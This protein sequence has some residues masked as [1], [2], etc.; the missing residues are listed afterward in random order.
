MSAALEAEVAHKSGNSAAIA[1][2]E[3]RLGLLTPVLKGV[4]TDLGFDNCVAAQQ[5]LGGHGYIAEWGMEQFVRDA[6]IA[7]IYEGANGIQ[8]LDLVGRKLPKDGGPR[9]LGLCGRGLGRHRGGRRGRGARGARATHGAGPRP[10]AAGHALVHDPRDRQARQ[11]RRR[12]STDYMHLFGLVALGHMWLLMAQGRRRQGAGRHRRAARDEQARDWRR[13]F[14]ERMVPESAIAARPHH[15]SGADSHHGLAG[16]SVL[17]S[18]VSP[19]PLA[20][21]GA[22]K[23]RMRGRFGW[24]PPPRPAFG[25]LLPRGEKGIACEVSCRTTHRSRAGRRAAASAAPCAM[26]MARAA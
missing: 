24:H 16:R 19:S 15:G 11:C 1:A 5:V 4:C 26:S 7:M 17:D 3:D 9:L 6:R 2:A 8:A 13:F 20:G 22:P 18:R 14:M 25:H 10:P 12:R 21:E 23:G